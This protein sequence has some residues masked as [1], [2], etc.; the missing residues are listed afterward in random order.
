MTTF[1]PRAE[2]PTIR[3]VD[4]AYL[5]FRIVGAPYLADTTS[6]S[7]SNDCSVGQTRGTCQNNQRV[8]AGLTAQ[9]V[10]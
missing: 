8:G 1:T 10:I 6:T 3:I 4:I 7:V 5:R 9:P 2:A